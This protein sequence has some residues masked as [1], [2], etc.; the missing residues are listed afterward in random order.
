M[1]EA[2]TQS[3]LLNQSNWGKD[4]KYLIPSM[5][6]F[7]VAMV[8]KYPDYS[9]QYYTQL[10]EIVKYLLSTEIRMEPTGL[11]LAGAVFER[12]GIQDP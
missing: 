5:G 8:C 6:Q 4:M 1:Y 11:E 10:V 3:L 9:K 7:L 12:L 2:I